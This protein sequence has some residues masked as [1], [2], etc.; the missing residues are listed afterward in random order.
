MESCY[1][2]ADVCMEG[3]NQGQQKTKL[4]IEEELVEDIVIQ[5][6]L[7]SEVVTSAR[8]LQETANACSIAVGLTLP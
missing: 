3:T 1:S 4:C 2:N 6:E 5:K 7:E 8:Q